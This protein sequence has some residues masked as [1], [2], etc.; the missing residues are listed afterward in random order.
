VKLEGNIIRRVA[1]KKVCIV[2]LLI[3]SVIVAGSRRYAGEGALRRRGQVRLLGDVDVL[4][5]LRFLF[6]CYRTTHQEIQVVC[7]LSRICV[8][9]D[10][11]LG[12][13]IGHLQ[14]V[15][16]SKYKIIASFHTY[17]SLHHT[18]ILFSLLCLHKFLPGNGF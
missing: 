5:V 9:I 4:V 10:R 18:L 12:L 13:E 7:I 2:C 6:A 17:K 1:N 11:G 3:L 14:V 15:N 8:T 16:T